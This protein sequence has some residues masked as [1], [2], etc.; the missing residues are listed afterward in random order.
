[1]TGHRLRFVVVVTVVSAA[2]PAVGAAQRIPE[3]RGVPRPMPRFALPD[4]TLSHRI[5]PDSLDIREWLATRRGAPRATVVCPMPV[6][7]PVAPRAIPMPRGGPTG[8]HAIPIPI[9]RS[10]C[11]NSLDQTRFPAHLL[12]PE[13]L[14]G[15]PPGRSPR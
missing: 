4:S 10:T 11:R 15:D 9:D 7:R 14:P 5:V 8:P 13:R 12:V 2:L 3:W 1:M 6:A